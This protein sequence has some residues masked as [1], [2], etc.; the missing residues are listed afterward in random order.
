[1]AAPILADS[2]NRDVLEHEYLK[3]QSEPASVDPTWQAF[4]A[5][6]E[7]AGNGIQQRVDAL[8]QATGTGAS[9]ADLRLQTGVVR[10]VFW[11]RQIG[12]LQAYTDPLTDA[13][14]PPHPLLQLDKFGLTEADLD[15]VVDASMLFGSPDRMTLREL[16]GVVKDT[17]CGKV[18]VEFVHIDDLEKRVWLAGRMEPARNR[19]NFPLAQKYRFLMTLHYATMFEQ[20]LH[21]KYVGQKRFSLEGGAA[22]SV[23]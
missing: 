18:G 11:Y 17:Y 1:M 9:A 23:A 10:L 12:H 5:G 19:A 22:A 13:P 6:A 4:F 3:W 2:Y 15:T 20:Y 7:F 21:T 14:P 16:V 8:P